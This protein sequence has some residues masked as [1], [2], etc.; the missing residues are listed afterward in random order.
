MSAKKTDIMSGGKVFQQASATP[1]TAALR[2]RIQ[3]SSARVSMLEML[4]K[5]R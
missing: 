5:V 2:N 1:S 4:R 3:K